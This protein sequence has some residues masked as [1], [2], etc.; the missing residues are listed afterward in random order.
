MAYGPNVTRMFGY[1]AGIVDRILK[2]AKP[3]DLPVEQPTEFDL[4]DQP[5]DGKGASADD[6]ARDTHA[7]ERGDPVTQR[8]VTLGSCRPQVHQHRDATTLG[9]AAQPPAGDA[10]R[11]AHP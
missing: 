3:A 2:G 10:P 7:G 11:A 4:H 1:A 6:T 5:Q 8:A 9:N